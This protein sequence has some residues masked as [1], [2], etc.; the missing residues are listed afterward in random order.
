MS[1]GN[2]FF[3]RKQQEEMCMLAKMKN[4][5]YKLYF[6]DLSVL[7]NKEIA[8]G[9]AAGFNGLFEIELA[10]GRCK[11]IGLFPYEELLQE[12]IHLS[13]VYC[14]QKAFFFPQRGN[15][16]SVYD[17]ENKNFMQINFE[18]CDYPHYNKNFKIG[19][20]FVH[21]NRVFAVG[22]M[23]PHVIVINA[24]T[25]E[26]RFIPIE[27]EGRPI[28]FRAGGCQVRGHY[29]LRSLKGG[30]IVE[31][32]PATEYVKSH[33]WGT[34][35]DGAWSMAFA[36][37]EFW[38]TPYADKEG[39]RIWE[40]G[41]G[42]V[43]EITDFPEGYRAGNMPYTHC[44]CVDKEI[45]YPPF[46][47]NMMIALDTKEKKIKKIEQ[48]IFQGGK[49]SG[50]YFRVDSYVFIKIRMGEESWYAQTGKEF[51]INMR[52]MEQTE[53]NFVLCENI[54]QFL[55]DA[56]EEMKKSSLWNSVMEENEKFDLADF[57]E[58]L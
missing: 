25:L 2:V 58:V 36:E 1:N 56:A 34:E 31:I 55:L 26:T 45:L 18:E 20:V 19:Q 52:T 42:I 12:Y 22:A 16:I 6:N 37:E 47:A 13:A 46:D 35:D 50:L 43:Q 8:Y 39:F 29:Y 51:F 33:F 28:F 7:P 48:S 21:E 10:S 11:Y 44:F 32:D 27:T 17:I 4:G 41:N 3:K 30:I 57:L 24:D 23:Y 15:Y 14:Q 38:L 49:I 53:Y 54:E 5:A 9:S 40:P